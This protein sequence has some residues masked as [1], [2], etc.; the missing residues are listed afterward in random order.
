MPRNLSARL[1]RELTGRAVRPLLPGAGFLR[2][3]WFREPL[4]ALGLRPLPEVGAERFLGEVPERLLLPCV[5]FRESAGG[6]SAPPWRAREDDPLLPLPEAAPL[7]RG[8]GLGRSARPSLE[9]LLG[10]R[11]DSLITPVLCGGV[12]RLQRVY[13]YAAGPDALVHRA[14]V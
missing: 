14:R 4:P 10:S 1:R 5:R 2:G 3:R 13:A 11:F 6:R 8:R 7:V 12:P 9:R